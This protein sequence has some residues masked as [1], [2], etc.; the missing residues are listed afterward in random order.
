MKS[1]QKCFD[2]FVFYINVWS[3]KKQL[4]YSGISQHK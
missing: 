1:T 4:T 3:W 2:K